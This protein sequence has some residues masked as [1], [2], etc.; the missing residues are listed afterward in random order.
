MIQLYKKPFTCLL[1]LV[2]IVFL[3]TA[4]SGDGSTST[5]E[6]TD[7]TSTEVTTDAA[8]TTAPELPPSPGNDDAQFYWWNER[9]FYEIFVRS[10]LDSDG[11]GDGDFTGLIEKLDYL[12]PED[13]SPDEDLGVGGVWLMPIFPSPSYHGYDVID[14]YDVNPDYGTMEDFKRVLDEVHARDIKVIIDMVINHTSDQ[15]PWFIESQNPDSSFRDWYI[16]SETNPGTQGPWGQQVWHLDDSGYYYAVFWGGMPDLNYKN[17]EVV[18][19]IKEVLRFWLE[20][21]GVDGFRIDGARHFV[22]ED[23]VYADTNANHEIFKELRTHIKTI[24]PDALLLG[25]VWTSNFAVKKYMEGD[26]LDLAF[27]FD[28]AGAFMN[29][30]ASG[31]ANSALNQLSFSLKQFP[32]SQF[33]PFLTNHDMERVMSQL[34]EDWD[35]AKNAATM[36]LTSPGVPFIYYGEEIGM[37][38]RKPD[39]KIRTPMQWSDEKHAG[40][41]T[42][43]PWIPVNTDYPEKNA[44]GQSEDPE[45]LLSFYRAL[46]ELRNQYD[47]LQIGDTYLINSESPA[48]YAILRVR[49]DETLMVI[50]N[51]SQEP[52]TDYSLSQSDGPLEGS[53]QVVPLFG[54]GEFF[55]LSSNQQGGF[56]K[57]QPLKILPS[58]AR[59]ILQLK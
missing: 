6:A 37:V 13:T 30:A 7:L 49:G 1:L 15:H 16:W 47:A 34:G 53:Y 23:G 29:S 31:R 21:V 2:V 35:K 25:E 5:V 39:E 33:A 38:G 4:C 18:E 55:D 27:D 54:D 50:V 41:T 43:F 11:D 28:L 40:F 32:H 22:E 59:L 12:N 52:I 56:D 26:E 24:N 51:L 10:F 20:D 17:P 48:V 44:T 9:V 58:N 57:Y 14:Y 3:L 46:I 42:G 8:Q 45:S 19:E 36:L